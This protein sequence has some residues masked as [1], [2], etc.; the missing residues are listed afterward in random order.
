MYNW[1]TTSSKFYSTTNY[2]NNPHIKIILKYYRILNNNKIKAN[3][4]QRGNRCVYVLIHVKILQI[5]RW[6]AVLFRNL[7]RFHSLWSIISKLY[8]NQCWLND[9]SLMSIKFQRLKWNLICKVVTIR[10]QFFVSLIPWL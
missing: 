8:N 3:E 2:K 7:E 9:L 1:F 4:N 10:W 6:C 5:D